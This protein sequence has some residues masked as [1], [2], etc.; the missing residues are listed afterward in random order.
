M[1]VPVSRRRPVGPPRIYLSLAFGLLSAFVLPAS[2]QSLFPN[3]AYNTGA[4]PQSVVIADINADGKKDL[5]VAN[6]GS[7]TV[8]VLRGNG[9]GTFGAKTDY[10][11]GNGPA[12]V[13]VADLNND[14]RPD[15]VTANGGTNSISV[16]LNAGSGVF[17]AKNDY[18]IGTTASASSVT[19]ADVNGDGRPD[20]IVTHSGYTD[21]GGNYVPNSNISVFLNAGNGTFPNRQDFAVGVSPDFV[22]VA[23]LNKDGKADIVV[24]NNGTNTISVLIGT[25][26]GGFAP[27]VTYDVG[28]SPIAL[29][30]ADINGDGKP[31]II[32]GHNGYFT[33]SGTFV[34]NNVL[35]LLPGNGDGTFGAKTDI[36][37]PDAPVSVAVADV[38]GD[39]KPDI[40]T[41]DSA[42]FISVLTNAGGG[43]FPNPLTL[44]V[45]GFLSAL[46]VSDVNGDGKPDVVAVNNVSGIAVVLTGNGNGTFGGTANSPVGAYPVAAAL[47]DVNGDGKPDLVTANNQ[48]GSFSVL[49]GTGG[50]AFG[51]DTDFALGDMPN[52]IALGDVNGDGQLDLIVTKNGGNVSVLLGKGDGTFGTATDYP[53][54]IQPAGIAI[55]D[56]NGDGKPDLIVGHFSYYDTTNTY[57]ANGFVSVFSGNG[58]GTFGAKTDY[59]VGSSP[60]KVAVADISG[61]GKPEIL[62]AGYDDNTVTVLSNSGTGTF[63]VRKDYP[64]ADSPNALAV[65]DMNGD[66]KPDVVTANR[67]NTVSV[68][69]NA[70]SGTFGTKTDYVVGQ[71]PIAIAIADVTGDGKPDIITAN[72]TDNSVSVVANN[73]AGT[74]I[75]AAHQ[76]YLTGSGPNALAVGNLDGSGRPDLVTVNGDGTATV[77]LNQGAVGSRIS[78]VITFTGLVAA[79]PARNVTFIFRPVGG[80]VSFT[81]TAVVPASG[82]FTLT[83]VP[84]SAYQV[85]VKGDLFLA[86]LVGADNSAGDVTNF[87]AALLGGDADN[88]NIVD[89]GDFGILVNAYNS[90]SSIANSGYDPHA[91]FDG[92]GVVDIADFG[93]L[94]NDYNV[95]GA[96]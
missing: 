47:G 12:S 10:L 63:L 48:G 8:S 62:A 74:G 64:V 93:V 38:N 5:I 34:L 78:G 79:A 51:L 89:I 7:N 46:A 88:N 54:G 95:A 33:M 11:T 28:E 19:L 18:G 22:S 31:D 82:I 91:D 32:I 9:D 49:P 2:A 77:L 90:D 73:G 57:Q 85:W 15:I 16:L 66:G 69:F 37:L 59:P 17:A 20:V 55:A 25:G 21:S 58:D 70:G 68:L 45:T 72:R 60:E 24:A 71:N 83:N 87:A 35:T 80:G 86:G 84:Q 65:A 61:D 67:G 50:G 76:D 6:A 56:V 52:A 40:L 94:V 92:N 81:R 42:G 53:A 43:T 3:P 44:N 36:V 13:A 96:E 75:F 1:N 4:A 29:A 30:I 41:A 23:D 26:G 14:G 39:T 27:Q